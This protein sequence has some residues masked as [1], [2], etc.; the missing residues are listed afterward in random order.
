MKNV[1]PKVLI[2]DISIQD[3]IATI[4]NLRM[5]TSPRPVK[6]RLGNKPTSEV[7][8]KYAQDLAA[9]EKS[10]ELYLEARD[11]VNKQHKELNKVLKNKLIEDAGLTGHAKA[12]Q[13]WSKAWDKG[14]SSGW[15]EVY[16][17]LCDLADLVL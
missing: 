11:V 16:L 9:Y 2:K 14:H 15:N 17:E 5:K 4:N 3:A 6:P 12:E 13:C 7:A 10:F 1:H 8:F